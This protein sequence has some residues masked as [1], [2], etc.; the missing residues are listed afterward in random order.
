[1][2]DLPLPL[3]SYRVDSA[4]SARLVNT[5][6]EAA[7]E[8]AKGPV[9]LR[10]APGIANYCA[11]GVGPGRGLHVMAGELFAV[12]GAKLYRITSTATEVGTVLGAGLVSTA[13]NGTQLAISANDQLYVYDSG[14][15]HECVGP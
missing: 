6:A 9:I 3:H 5:Y 13:N 15:G 4:S 14:A 1:M 12:S 2:A 10:R 7:P 8:G 11:C